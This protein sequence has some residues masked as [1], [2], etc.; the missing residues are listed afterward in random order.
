MRRQK[1]RYTFSCIFPSHSYIIFIMDI[2]PGSLRKRI[3]LTILAGISIILFSFGIVS[4]IIIQKNIDDS[5]AKRLA[6]SRLIRNNID[7]ILKDNINRLY[8]ISLSGSVDLEDGNFEPERE[9]LKA[10]YRYSLFT[11]GI[12]LLD[13]GGTVILNYPERIREAALNVLSV[14]P[15]GRMIS[16]GKPVVS[17]IYTTEN[18]RKI[19][20]VLVP[21]KDRNGKNVGVA[22]G[23]I[24]PTNPTLIQKLGLMDI[25][26]D[27]F[28]DLVDSN[29]VIISSTNPSRILTQYNRNRFFTK[30][31]TDKKERVATC[32]GCHFS[33]KT[34]DK[35]KTV[36]AFVPLETAPWGISLQESEGT[37]FMPATKLKRYF[38]VLT[39][40]FI[41]TAFLLTV[42]I[43]RSIINPLKE[44][45]RGTDRIARGDMS[46]P[47]V[48]QGSDE[49]G[50]LSQSFETMR[51]RLIE[52]MESIARHT[53]EL[54][55]RVE[56]RTRQINESQRRA[57]ELLKKVIS[58]QEDERK[59]I[60][61]ELHNDTL[62]ELSATLMRIDICKLHPEDITLAKVDEIR[63][64]ISQALDGVVGIIQNLRPTLLDDLGLVPAI[65]S[66][67]DLHL[68]ESGVHYF[69]NAKGVTDKRFRPE[70][71][72]T[73]F[74]V[75]QEA[76]MNIASHAHAE[77]VFV[78]FKIEQNAVNVEIEDDG[79][80]FAFNSFFQPGI[81][82]SKSKR[83]LGLLGMKERVFLIGGEIKISSEP[84]LGT[85]ISIR[86][87]LRLLEEAHA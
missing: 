50:V 51:L 82:D 52:S 29:G 83:G 26:T 53:Q 18:G 69:M 13:K 47:I 81:N 76:V 68:G 2:Q 27:M 60:A 42:G 17:N 74:R 20:Y 80:G 67:L 8:D 87:P 48:P 40:I 38:A 43:S 1:G 28:I 15:V 37:I 14:E 56:E 30:L 33:G 7:N 57:E 71:E 23:Q 21:L 45:I 65:K 5:L 34:G 19:L 22:G 6:L 24:D 39:L 55:T 66:L 62:Q 61:R 59:R 32:Y 12:F 70:V 64:I 9:A 85:Q 73:L 4:H 10:A 11:D 79:E 36:L 25:G 49:I 77:N 3:T 63:G 44:L 86:I 58:S 54:E 16:V 46:K 72:I 78:L 41:G 35:Q 75:I 31:I 84:G